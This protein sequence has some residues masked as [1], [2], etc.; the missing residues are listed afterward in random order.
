MGAFIVTDVRESA[1]VCKNE[2]KRL[3]VVVP[4][5]QL[6][7]VIRKPSNKARLEAV[8]GAAARTTPVETAYRRR[9]QALEFLLSQNTLEAN[10]VAYFGLVKLGRVKD[11]SFGER[12]FLATAKQV[13]VAEVRAA[14]GVSETKAEARIADALLT[15]DTNQTFGQDIGAKH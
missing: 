4:A 8:L 7:S 13:L 3:S 12:R 11:L 14:L 6:G 1:V 9:A 10:A 15:A 2:E 5:A